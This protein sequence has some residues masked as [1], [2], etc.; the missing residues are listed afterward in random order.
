MAIRFAQLWIA[1]SVIGCGQSVALS[2]STAI[3]PPPCTSLT[4]FGNGQTCS[5][6]D[7]TLAACGTSG[8]R[9][10]ADGWLCYDAPEYAQCTCQTD[11]DCAGK[12]DYVNTARALNDKA[13]VATTCIGGR[14]VDGN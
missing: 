3:Q 10:C 5:S 13:P 2:P 9:L 12:R 8:S 4:S 7:G 14:C 11:A 6:A 1:L